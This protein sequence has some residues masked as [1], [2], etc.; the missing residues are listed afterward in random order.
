M[1]QK[2]AGSTVLHL[3]GMIRYR[4]VIRTCGYKKLILKNI[5]YLLNIKQILWKLHTAG[6]GERRNNVKYSP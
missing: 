1:S 4:K 2:I 3:R 6:S 5:L